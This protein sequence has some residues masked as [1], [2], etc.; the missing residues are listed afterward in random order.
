MVSDRAMRRRLLSRPAHYTAEDSARQAG[1][2][3]SDGRVK[4]R[5]TADEYGGLCLLAK[6]RVS[7][8]CDA[9]RDGRSQGTG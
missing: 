4:A 1:G 8:G 3:R 6:H 2:Q 7:R 5:G 9:L